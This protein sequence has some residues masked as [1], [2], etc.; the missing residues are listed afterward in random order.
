M[1]RVAVR[2]A[3]DRANCSKQAK[4]ASLERG[5]VHENVRVSSSRVTAAA[6]GSSSPL[7]CGLKKSQRI[8]VEDGP[9]SS[10]KRGGRRRQAAPLVEA[11]ALQKAFEDLSRRRGEQAFDC[12]VYKSLARA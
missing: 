3:C 12:G 11:G 4:Q 1:E 5:P 6:L 2:E 10:N 7:A 9:A 8:G